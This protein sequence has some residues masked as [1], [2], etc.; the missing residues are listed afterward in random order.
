MGRNA[1]LNPV[2]PTAHLDKLTA[3]NKL[4]LILQHDENCDMEHKETIHNAAVTA[5]KD[6]A[7]T[8]D[9]CLKQICVFGE[10]ISFNTL[11]GK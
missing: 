5:G 9:S 3:T 10:S 6:T 8:Q 4:I 7:T 11:T 1:L 2:I